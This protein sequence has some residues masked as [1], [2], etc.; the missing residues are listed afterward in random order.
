[1]F[2]VFAGDHAFSRRWLR[3]IA[4]GAAIAG[5]FLTK[6][7]M[8]PASIALLVFW[9]AF[10]F[11]DR[12]GAGRRVSSLLADSSVAVLTIGL[13]VGMWLAFASSRGIRLDAAIGLKTSDAVFRTGQFTGERAWRWIIL[14]ALYL[15]VVLAP[16]LPLLLGLAKLDWKQRIASLPVANRMRA[17]FCDHATRFEILSLGFLT[18]YIGVTLI[19]DLS[20]LVNSARP[21]FMSSRY[22]EF[23]YPLLIIVCF[24]RIEALARAPVQTRLYG[25][26]ASTAFAVALVLF[27]LLVFRA[28][29]V[30][31]I[32]ASLTSVQG[33]HTT[34]F[35][36]WFN[37]RLFIPWVLAPIAVAISSFLAWRAG[38]AMFAGGA[39]VACT[40]ALAVAGASAWTIERGRFAFKPEQIAIAREVGSLLVGPASGQPAVVFSREPERNP[41]IFQRR[42]L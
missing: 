14:Y 37:N 18:F 2:M 23:T 27:G 5:C 22:F 10:T 8:L 13:M 19:H 24:G 4:V 12:A 1:M 29:R 9:M 3:D 16:F 17:A 35:S 11:L 30:F 15:G 28:Q 41:A 21:E 33:I 38:R 40:L 25:L 20:Y 6:F 42:L 39:L 32:S 26:L 34:T 36:L 31:D 7:I